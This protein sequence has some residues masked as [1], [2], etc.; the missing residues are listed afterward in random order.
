MESACAANGTYEAIGLDIV[1]HLA[2]R[3]MK[4]CLALA[5]Q[6]NLQRDGLRRLRY[7]DRHIWFMDRDGFVLA[8]LCAQTASCAARVLKFNALQFPGPQW[9]RM[10]FQSALRA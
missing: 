5:A 4:R 7:A 3:E 2:C 6:Q 8:H 10:V 1:G 9:V